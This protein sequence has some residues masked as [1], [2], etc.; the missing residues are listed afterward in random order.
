VIVQF[1]ANHLLPIIAAQA[2]EPK[3]KITKNAKQAFSSP[4]TDKV[5]RKPTMGINPQV[6]RRRHKSI[7]NSLGT[8]GAC[9]AISAL[10]SPEPA[11]RRVP[12]T[13]NLRRAGVELVVGHFVLGA[14]KAY[15]I[16]CQSRAPQPA[17]DM[18]QR[19]VAGKAPYWPRSRR[20]AGCVP[21]P[22]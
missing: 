20:L 18:A 15:V 2:H 12:R 9:S 1:D 4:P 17:I 8:G 16:I 21:R 10:T 6:Y 11:L 13:S 3:P 14:R 19:A 22:S 7:L 5:V